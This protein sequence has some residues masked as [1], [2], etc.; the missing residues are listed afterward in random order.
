MK[1]FF[2][3]TGNLIILGFITAA[4]GMLFLAYKASTIKFDMVVKGD[5]YQ[6]EVNYNDFLLA[7]NNGRQIGDDFNFKVNGDQLILNIPDEMS[8][9]LTEGFIEFYCVSNSEH[10][11]IQKLNEKSNGTY[12]FN[13]SEI[14]KGQN[15]LVKVSFKVDEKEFYK[16]FRMQ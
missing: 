1:Q 12:L 4:V 6:L 9:N 16:E 2:S 14:A 13:R 10:D 8:Q 7:K 11:Y 3:N 5:Y 15:Y